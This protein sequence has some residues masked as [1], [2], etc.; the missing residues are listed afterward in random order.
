MKDLKIK[1]FVLLGLLLGACKKDNTAGVTAGLTMGSVYI[2]EAASADTLSYIAPVT[3]DSV[4]TMRIS[5]A[6][7]N[8][9]GSGG[10]TVYFRIDTSLMKKY[11]GK[12]G[13]AMLLPANNYFVFRQLVALGDTTYP[14]EINVIKETQLLPS[15]T[16]VLPVTIDSIQGQPE[17]VDT[18]KSTLFLLV[19]TGKSPF[20]PKNTWSVVDYSSQSAAVYSPNNL[21]DNDPSTIWTTVFNDVMPQ[22][23]VIDMGQAY[24]ISAVNF[25]AANN[26]YG[27][28]KNI[29]IQVSTD[30]AQWSDMG[31]FPGLGVLTVQSLHIG[32]VT[33]RYVRFTVLDAAPLVY[34]IGTNT[35]TYLYVSMADISVRLAD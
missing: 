12:Y 15:A 22:Y 14:A 6:V 27:Y 31:T 1:L 17:A 35:I 18:A 8:R 2:R 16:Y 13:N 25:T 7:K 26:L 20:V 24:R 34:T 30:G 32:P 21:I 28:P 5:A 29:N 23:V 10:H 19:K 3:A 11:I 4:I 33:A 9:F